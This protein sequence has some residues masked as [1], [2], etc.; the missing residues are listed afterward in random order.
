MIPYENCLTQEEGASNLAPDLLAQID[1]TLEEITP[2]C[3]LELLA[4]PLDSDHRIKREEGLLGVRNILWAVGRGG[5][6]A[7]GGG[8]T[9]ESFMNETYIRMTAA[10]QVRVE[11]LE[12]TADNLFQLLQQTILTPLGTLSEYAAKADCEIPFALERGLCSLLLGDVDECRMWL[13]IESD[14]SPY[15]DPAIVEFV[16]DNSDVDKDNDVLP[17]L[18]KLLETWLREV[19][20]PRF[21]DTH[22]IYFKLG[23]YYDDPM[24]LKYLERM[25]GDHGSPLAAAAAI[26]KIGAEEAT[27]ALGSVKSSVLQALQKVFPLTNKEE[28]LS[29]EEYRDGTDIVPG[30]HTQETVVK[31]DQDKSGPHVEVSKMSDP[32]DSNEQDL[33]N[34]IKNAV[35][36]IMSAGMVVGLLTLVGIKCLPGR[37]SLPV[38]GKETGSAIAANFTNIADGYPYLLSF[39]CLGTTMLKLDENL[40]EEIPKMDARFAETLVLDGRMLKIWTERAVEIAK[41]GWFWEYTLLGLTIDSVTVSLDGRR[42]MVEATIEEAARLTDD[43]HPEHNDSY[44]TTYSTRYEMVHFKSG[45][46]ITEGSVLQS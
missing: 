26:V 37:N 41:H 33:T 4:L 22:D 46:K 19:V 44:S 12:K 14:N 29:S 13:G 2:R 28:R 3:V 1:E 40:V 34:E 36:K 20:F 27:A 42:A 17:G 11:S 16:M 23:D 18:C 8:F 25:E 5:A 15:R 39:K 45:W 10:E 38:M 9:R 6:A 7:I 43:K 35:M 21:R 31:N 32:E 30:L 24:V